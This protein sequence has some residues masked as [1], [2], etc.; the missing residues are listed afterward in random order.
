MQRSASNCGRENQQPMPGCEAA[1]HC[2]TSKRTLGEWDLCLEINVHSNLHP[3]M[4]GCWDCHGGDDW[5]E[6]DQAS[7]ATK[8]KQR[9][10]DARERALQQRERQIGRAL[11]RAAYGALQVQLGARREPPAEQLR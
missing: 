5:A 4:G 6:N 11:V 9:L 3:W 10:A 7:D 8:A 2:M 1:L